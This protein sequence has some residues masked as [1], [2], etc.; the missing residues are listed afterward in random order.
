MNTENIDEETFINNEIK[1]ETEFIISLLNIKRKTL[2]NNQ[3]QNN[4]NMNFNQMVFQPNITQSQNE[5]FQNQM[6]Q[7]ND[8][9]KNIIN[10]LFWQDWNNRSIIVNCNPNELVSE[11]IKIYRNKTGIYKNN[12]K[13]L[14]NG[15]EIDTSKS[16]IEN[17]MSA[18]SKIYIYKL[19]NILNYGFPKNG[20][21]VKFIN[22]KSE[23][24][25]IGLLPNDTIERAI[26]CLILSGFS[27]SNET[28][29]MGSCRS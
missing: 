19:G 23:Q 5:I 1:K 16:I 4:M 25:I 6:N 7:I 29:T 17:G 2:N 18:N 28:R 8:N 13:F 22:E 20:I 26:Y 3:M 11:I 21:A 9:H 12:L 24:I 27:N 14:F 10:I 15:K